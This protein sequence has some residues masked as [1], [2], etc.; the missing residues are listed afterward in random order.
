M[1]DPSPSADS[2]ADAG[3][4]PWNVARLLAFRFVFA[5]LLLYNFQ[6]CVQYTASL[7]GK[8]ARA[9]LWLPVKMEWVEQ[10]TS[11][12]VGAAVYQPVLWLQQHVQS[13]NASIIR[14]AFSIEI[15]VFPNGSGDTTYNYFEIVIFTAVALAAT[16]VWSVVAS[17]RGGGRSH[18]RLHAFLRVYVRFVLALT[19]IGYGMAKVIKL[20]FPDPDPFRLTETFGEASPMGI[21]WALMGASWGYNVF[22]GLG[23]VIGGLLLLWRRT[24]MLG[25]LVTAAVMANVVALNFSFDVPVKLYSSHLFLQAIWLALPGMSHLCTLLLSNRAIPE[26][27]PD[28]RWSRPALH[29]PWVAIKSLLIAVYMAEQVTTGIAGYHSVGDGAKLPPLVG[30]FRVES[31][32]SDDDD[33]PPRPESS[34]WREVI[35]GRT[36]PWT[37][38]KGTMRIERANRAR[39]HFGYSA[40]YQSQVLV[41][42]P[43]TAGRGRVPTADPAAAAADAQVLRFTQI[44]ADR[45]RLQGAFEGS[46]ID[47]LLVRRP[48]SEFLL[49]NRGF[50][51]I[52]EYPFNR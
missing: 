43:A 14:R 28:V 4:P 13:L 26:R 12:S 42:T 16:I 1:I 30:L 33:P 15:T 47:V 6:S 52:N 49:M 51:W 3:P 29:R 44:D 9:V 5:Y 19:M 41:L 39:T 35:I 24:T 46:Q 31:F 2:A 50:H 37:G 23:E 11:A 40:D 20:Q 17:L 22:G 8:A 38:D 36:Y 45:I 27:T 10:Q 7:A 48:A 21:L 34:I 32:S 18:P 25:A